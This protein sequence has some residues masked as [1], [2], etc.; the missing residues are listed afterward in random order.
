MPLRIMYEK[1]KPNMMPTAR[2]SKELR[3]TDRTAEMVKIILVSDGRKLEI[4]FADADV[5]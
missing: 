1:L 2:V 5:V 4:F 3:L